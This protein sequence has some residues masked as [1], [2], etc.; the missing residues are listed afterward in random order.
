[1]D[2]IIIF[3]LNSY[4]HTMAYS[5]SGKLCSNESKL[6]TATLNNM[7]KSCRHGVKER[8]QKSTYSVIPFLWNTKA[9]NTYAHSE[10]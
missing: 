4:L 9:G 3:I 10:K 1:M 8:R 2:F 6:F 7:D 5:Y